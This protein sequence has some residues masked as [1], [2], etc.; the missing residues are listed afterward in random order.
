[1]TEVERKI[2]VLEE[3]EMDKK[4]DV[5]EKRNAIEGLQKAHGDID[6]AGAK[7]R[8]TVTVEEYRQLS[9]ELLRVQIEG[10]KAEAQL[11]P[12]PGRPAGGGGAGGDRGR[13]GPALLQRQAGRRSPRAEGPR[14][15]EV[16]GHQE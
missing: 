10:V 13:P 11:R 7:E 15:G 6:V 12:A 5:S 16:Q 14:R 4:R 9:N 3:A 2:K 1:M 8:N